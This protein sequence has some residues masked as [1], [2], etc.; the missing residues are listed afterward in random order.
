MSGSNSE[1]N[2]A[3]NHSRSFFD[4]LLDAIYQAVICLSAE[5]LVLHWNSR[6]RALYGHPA[7]GN[8][9]RLNYREIDEE[10]WDNFQKVIKTGE[11]LL[12]LR[13]KKMDREYIAIGFP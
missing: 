6:A 4:T 9:C 11:P 8:K 5:G 1:L 12:G 7:G 10:G 2:A 3:R 13:V